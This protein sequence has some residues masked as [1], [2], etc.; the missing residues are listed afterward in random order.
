MVGPHGSGKTTFLL[1]L[2]QQWEARSRKVIRLFTARDAGRRIP[3][4]WINVLR[5][6]EESAL[7]IADGYDVLGPFSRWWLRR[8]LRPRGGL[9]VTAHRQ[10]ALPTVL[11]T[12]TSPH[13]LR[14]LVD[15]LYADTPATPPVG[16]GHL[17]PLYHACHGNLREVFRRLYSAS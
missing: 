2:Q 17:G 10:C 13:L 11:E 9:I 7:A 5:A 6:A 12:W 3:R 15:E 4:A 8:V 14:L 16:D 1:E